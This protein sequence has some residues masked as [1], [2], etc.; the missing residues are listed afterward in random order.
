MNTKELRQA[1]RNG[2]YA[3]PGGYPLMVV[4]SD[5]ETLCFKCARKE[6]RQISHAIRHHDRSGWR[7]DGID[8]N[9]E[10]ADAMCCH[11]NE[12]IQSA[13]GDQS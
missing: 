3:W 10:D 6:Y 5:G 12:P 4:M 8:V 11:C 9:W 2:P 1:L 7:A 13:Y